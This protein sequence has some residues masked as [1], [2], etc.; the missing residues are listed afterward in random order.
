MAVDDRREAEEA[1]ER[2]ALARGVCPFTSERLT[3]W[4]NVRVPAGTLS[5]G[6][7]DCF[8]YGPEEVGRR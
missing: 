1:R 2:A 8:G 3:V 5:C 4:G 7:C 6:V